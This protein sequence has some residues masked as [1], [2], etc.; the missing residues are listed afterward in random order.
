MHQKRGERA[1]PA[2]RTADS[3]VQQQR[4]RQ[5]QRRGGGVARAGRA[6][7]APRRQRA[8]RQRQPPADE[9]TYRLPPESGSMSMSNDLLEAVR[10]RARGALYARDERQ[11]RVPRVHDGHAA[12]H[13]ARRPAARARLRHQR[14]HRPAHAHTYI[15]A[16]GRHPRSRTG[17]PREGVASDIVPSESVR[18]ERPNRATDS[19]RVLL[20]MF[21]KIVKTDLS[22]ASSASAGGGASAAV[23]ARA[24]AAA[25]APPA[26]SVQ[27]PAAAARAGPRRSAAPPPPP[28]H[29][30]DNSARTHTRRYLDDDF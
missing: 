3:L 25:P 21:Y 15:S 20:G 5:V 14:G 17:R 8:E 27:R 1:L 4:G 23:R 10:G 26:S 29:A 13:A 2:A 6:A 24:A 30:A 9:H 28:D 7:R 16:I 12:G 22:S 11:V 18:S 19:S